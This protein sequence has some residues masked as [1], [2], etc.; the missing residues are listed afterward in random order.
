MNFRRLIG[1]VFVVTAFA[2]E[3]EAVADTIGGETKGSADQRIGEVYRGIEEFGKRVDFDIKGAEIR[4][5]PVLRQIVCRVGFQPFTY[6]ALQQAMGLREDEIKDAV[7]KLKLMA[8]VKTEMRDGVR[9]VVPFDK[10]TAE[11]MRK[12]ADDWCVGDDS[13]GV[14]K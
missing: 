12:W 8:M 4:L 10:E 7:D 11:V 3:H 5:D 13:C 9:L 2:S 1:V 14:K 6:A